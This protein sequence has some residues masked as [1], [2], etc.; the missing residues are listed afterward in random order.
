MD[1]IRP[2]L[3]QGSTR[4]SK[5]PAHRF[6]PNPSRSSSFTAES[7]RRAGLCCVVKGSWGEILGESVDV[8]L[9]DSA[10]DLRLTEN[11]VSLGSVEDRPTTGERCGLWCSDPTGLHSTVG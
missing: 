6:P 11:G 9:P 4:W 10:V 7:K 1:Q 5:T 2:P 8:P 3:L